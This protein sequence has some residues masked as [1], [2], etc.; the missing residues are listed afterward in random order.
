MYKIEEDNLYI[1]RII[2]SNNPFYIG[3]IAGVE[4][5]LA[6]YV[7][8]GTKEEYTRELEALENNAGIYTKTDQSVHE[9]TKQ[10]IESYDKC[11]LI[12][13]WEKAG[14][15]FSFNGIG[16]ELIRNRT[17]HIPKINAIALEPYY[18]ADSWMP[19]LKGKKIL[20]IHPFVKT[21]EKQIKSLSKLFPGRSWF[22]DCTIICISPPNTLAGNHGGK[23]WQEHYREF[24]ETLKNVN[25]FD[26]ALVA[27][28]GYGMLISN[29]IF[30]NMKRS[31][32]YIGGALQLFF[33]II[34]KRWFDNKQILEL[35][36]DDWIRPLS[37]DKPVNS[38]R[39]E[40]GCY[41]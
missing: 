6:H 19:S 21:I 15:V 14:K 37:L 28:G 40:K 1:K 13:E 12:G 10:L 31:V 11:T 2:E 26:V 9:Y 20:I 16:Q 30:T 39:V 41:W 32:M 18:F 22:E 38:V 33:G 24:I 17:S 3:R 25:D 5:K 27:A 29:Y 23:D 8:N 34:G 36:N 35:V 4:L 7:I